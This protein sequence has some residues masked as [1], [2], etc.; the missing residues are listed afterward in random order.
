MENVEVVEV[1]NNDH[2]NDD[3]NQDEGKCKKNMKKS[4]RSIRRLVQVWGR[5]LSHR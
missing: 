1:W 3:E 4:D 5:S 2:Q